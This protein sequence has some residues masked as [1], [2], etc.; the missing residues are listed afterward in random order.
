[1][2]FF[3]LDINLRRLCGCFL[4]KTA[5]TA[6]NR[7]QFSAAW[8]VKISLQITVGELTSICQQEMATDELFYWHFHLLVWFLSPSSRVSMEGG[9]GDSMTS[10]RRTSWTCWAPTVLLLPLNNFLWMHEHVPVKFSPR[11]KVIFPMTWGTSQFCRTTDADWTSTVFLGAKLIE[12]CSKRWPGNP[13]TTEIAK[14]V[15]LVS[16][17]KFGA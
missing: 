16:A 10:Q 1:M 14:G 9:P 6:L 8:K 12:K 4:S 15:G 17:P 11:T 2:L 13:V 5:V 3:S 7:K